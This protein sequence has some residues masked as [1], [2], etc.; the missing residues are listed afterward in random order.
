MKK[1]FKF[2][3]LLLA[4]V[5]ISTGFTSCSKDKEETNSNP[6]DTTPSSAIKIV[7]QQYVENVVYPTYTNLA[8]ETEKLYNQ[9]FA[10]KKAFRNNTLT[11]TDIDNICSTFKKARAYWEVSEAFLYGPATTFGIDP[12]IDTWP[13]AISD[14][15][16]E[17]QNTSKISQLDGNTEEEME[18]AISYATA[19]VGKELLGFHGIEFVI[20]RDGQNRTLAAL[21]APEDDINFTSALAPGA[22]VNGEEELIYATAIAGD[23]MRH[24]FQLQVAWMGN[25]AGKE[26]KLKVEDEWEMQ[27]LSTSDYYGNNMLM[28]TQAGSTFKMWQSVLITIL[29]SGCSNICNEVANTKIGNAWTG[30]DVNY[31]ES[32]Y[33]KMSFVDFR[34]NIQSIKNSL[35]G[36][37][38]L[39]TPHEHSILSLLQDKNPALY[40]EMNAKLEKALTALD[41]CIQGTSFVDIIKSSAKP[42]HV[43]NAIDAINDLDSQ[44]KAA[45]SWAATIE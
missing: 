14:L 36:G 38:N 31:I 29:N 45:S 43:Q 22:V 26:R 10:A 39:S 23:L 30:E 4:A 9:L 11:Q 34:D 40:N 2:S 12:H 18:D 16:L 44:L 1:F 32:P 7:T 13:L 33:S 3:M 6:I 15:A 19:F 17:L 5:T 41:I 35:Y 8:N 24:C 37:I 27:T 42:Q 25:A 21:Q 28:A 20:F